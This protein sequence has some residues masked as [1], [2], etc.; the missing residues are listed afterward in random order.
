MLLPRAC[1]SSWLRP[2]PT[3]VPGF[4]LV[5]QRTLVQA[6][7][8][9]GPGLMPGHAEV[10]VSSLHPQQMLLLLW[11]S[12]PQAFSGW[13]GWLRPFFIDVPGLVLFMQRTLA[14]AWSCRGLWLRPTSLEVPDSHLDPQRSLSPVYSIEV[15]PLYLFLWSSLPQAYSDKVC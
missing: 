13:G 12:L 6:K 11:S 3:N 2:V 4:G 9:R 15:T 14:W 8:P 7:S 1:W 10:S 5:L